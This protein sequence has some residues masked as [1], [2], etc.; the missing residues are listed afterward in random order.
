MNQSSRR[1]RL[2]QP[3]FFWEDVLEELVVMNF[4]LSENAQA[5]V[6]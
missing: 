5:Q 3:L 6:A 1:F 4:F 2:T